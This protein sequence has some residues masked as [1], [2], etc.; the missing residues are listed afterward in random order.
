MSD[1]T[2]PRPDHDVDGWRHDFERRL[3]DE[4]G[5]AEG[6]SCLTP[7]IKLA[8][9]MS[10][11]IAELELMLR[12]ADDWLGG[13]MGSASNYERVESFRQSIRALRIKP[14]T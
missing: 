6:C 5:C 3:N 4:I 10:D 1:P 2:E 14:T 7:A 13:W 11:R 8:E 12:E 9:D